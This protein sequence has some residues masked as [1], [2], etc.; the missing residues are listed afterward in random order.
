MQTPLLFC[1][2]NKITT[3]IFI[4][5]YCTDELGLFRLEMGVF[6]WHYGMQNS[7]RGHADAEDF[8]GLSF[9]V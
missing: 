4:Q 9:I 2:R 5:F 8:V 3:K 6:I 7:T 1:T